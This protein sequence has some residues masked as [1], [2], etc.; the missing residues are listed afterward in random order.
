MADFMARMVIR[1]ALFLG[2]DKASTLLIPWATYTDPEV[3]HVGLYPHD[4]EERGIP[5]TTFAREL[6]DVDRAILEG[7]TDGFVKIHIKKGGDQI[8]GAAMVSEHAGELISE[9]SVAMRAGMGL[10]TLAS[11]IHPY[12]TTAEAIRQTGDAYNRTRLTPFVKTLFRKWLG[13]GQ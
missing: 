13:W 9:I 7:D 12:P 3:A 5:F 10:G 4:L 6:A 8:L 2:R 1:N 11:V